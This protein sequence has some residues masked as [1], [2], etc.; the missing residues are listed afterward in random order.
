MEQVAAL[1]AEMT[2]RWPAVGGQSFVWFTT[3]ER[4]DSG[5]Y[6]VSST[7]KRIERLEEGK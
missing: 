4:W 7:I 6:R 3:P 1:T 2:G 5:K